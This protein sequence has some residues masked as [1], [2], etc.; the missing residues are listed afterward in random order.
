LTAKHTV[1]CQD[2]G[3]DPVY[4]NRHIGIC[5]VDGADLNL[6]HTLVL[7]GWALNFEP[8]PRGRFALEE[9]DAHDNRRGLWKG[10]FAAP[11]DFRRWRKSTAKLLGSACT[12]S[13]EM[14]ER[15]ELF[16][17]NPAMPPGCSIKAKLALRALITGH[18]GIYHMEG[19]RSYRSLK[20]PNRWFC[21]EEE[22]R[23]AGFRKALT[24]RCW[25]P[26]VEVK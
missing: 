15:N 26:S 18:R 7:E 21:S 4:P 13:N 16:P 11:W 5:S 6:N 24:C 25:G 23:T 3:P 10:C 19:C 22:A 1:Q 2:K 9:A 17:D 8:Y 14:K 12:S 20:S